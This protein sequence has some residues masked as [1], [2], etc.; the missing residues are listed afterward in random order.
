MARKIEVHWD[1]YHGSLPYKKTNK[2]NIL[3]KIKKIINEFFCKKCGSQKTKSDFRVVRE[4][5]FGFSGVYLIYIECFKCG[6]RK[7]M[8]FDE[9]YEDFKI[10]ISEEHVI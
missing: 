9:K 8:S 4:T 10:K 3:K 7:G 2:K 6:W 1:I 5:C